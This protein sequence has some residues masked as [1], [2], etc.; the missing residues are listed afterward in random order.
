[1]IASR[2]RP[3]SNARLLAVVLL[4]LGAALLLYSYAPY[5]LDLNS[6]VPAQQTTA[7]LSE[8]YDAECMDHCLHAAA[9]CRIMSAGATKSCCAQMGIAA[10]TSSESIACVF[11]SS[12][13]IPVL[14]SSRGGFDDEPHPG[15]VY[16]D[17]STSAP[18]EPS[19]QK[20]IAMIVGLLASIAGGVSAVV[21]IRAAGRSG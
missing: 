13:D 14:P 2:K 7:R 21:S 9:I 8:D 6:V 11:I 18:Q 4:P 16:L 1:M 12:D 15:G 3:A 17:A 20:L 5:E 19:P 10:G